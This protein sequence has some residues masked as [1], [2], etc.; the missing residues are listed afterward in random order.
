M[1]AYNIWRVVGEQAG[2]FPEESEL[3]KQRRSHIDLA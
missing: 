2:G 3:Q 1:G